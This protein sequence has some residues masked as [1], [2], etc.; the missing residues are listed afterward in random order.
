MTR[1]RVLEQSHDE[2]TPHTCQTWDNE[3]MHT[4]SSSA[5][6]TDDALDESLLTACHTVARPGLIVT[7]VDSTLITSEVIEEL[8]AYA[9]TRTEVAQ[10]TERAMNG[11]LDF[12]Q[13]LH[14]RVATLAGVPAEIF[15]SVLHHIEPTV[16]AQA[17]IDAQHRAGGYV[18]VVSGGF[19]EIVAPLCERMG[20]DHYA[21]NRL[22]VVHGVLTGRVLGRIVTAEVK[23]DMLRTW[24]S[25]HDT[26]LERCVTIGDGANDIPMLTEAGLG[27][28]FCAKPSVQ[29]AVRH[30]LNLPRL[31][32]LIEPLGL[33]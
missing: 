21:A 29:S 18:G 27:I 19:E 17:L 13:S 1:T 3:A 10:I 24:A 16:G 11:E 31:D 6:S 15:T 32:V 14:E 12:T 2:F 9:G 28:A 26:P 25:L 7:D 30:T 23:V 20:I 4:H 8:A 33:R 22:E 5:F